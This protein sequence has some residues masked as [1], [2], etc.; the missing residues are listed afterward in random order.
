MSTRLRKRSRQAWR[1]PSTAAE[2]VSA[3]SNEITR[4]AE[5]LLKAFMDGAQK[6]DESKERSELI[7]KNI[8][9]DIQTSRSLY[10][11]K[12]TAI[13]RAIEEGK[14]V[15]EIGRAAE[16]ISDIADQTHL[17]ALNAAIEAAR[18]GEQ[19]RG[20]A[21]V[22][23]EVRKLAEQSAKTVTSVQTVIR[24]VQD[25]FSNLSGTTGEL[26][27]Y[28]ND[29]VG[30]D[31][32]RMAKAGKRYREDAEIISDHYRR[33]INSL[34]QVTVSLEESDRVD[35]RGGSVMRAGC[36]RLP[37]DIPEHGDDCQGHSGRGP[38][39]RSP[40]GNGRKA[41]RHGAAVPC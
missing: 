40:G 6:A 3:S 39:Y 4:T 14:V 25:A 7:E 29:T 8:A 28:V 33:F 21:V 5:E 26:L 2:E 37:A 13:L 15:V 1:S 18:A 38:D 27:Q 31:Y 36:L 17:L 41:Q 23:G 34:E 12:E 35:G 9:T 16:I 30:Q 24:Q 20:F 22:A 19:G 32:N 10:R 11:E